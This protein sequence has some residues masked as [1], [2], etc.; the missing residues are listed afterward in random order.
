LEQTVQGDIGWIL[1][2]LQAV[3]LEQ[4]IVVDLAGPAQPFAVVRIIVPGLEGPY[5]G[6]DSSFVPGRRALALLAT[7][8]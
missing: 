6:D 3:G 2:R 8:S 1:Q 5:K 4:A 7:L